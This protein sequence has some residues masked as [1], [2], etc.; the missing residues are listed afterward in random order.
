MPKSKPKVDPARWPE[1][2]VIIQT[3]VTPDLAKRIA[4]YAHA[5][6]ITVAAYVRRLLTNQVPGG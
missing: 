4:A 2:S 5:E 1:F 6:T 3:R